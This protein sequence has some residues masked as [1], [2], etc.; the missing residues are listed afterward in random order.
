MPTDAFQL[1]K[2]STIAP[3]DVVLVQ[4]GQWAVESRTGNVVTVS[5]HHRTAKFAVVNNA[6]YRVARG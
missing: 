6:D 1:V 2:G 5:R 4:G 3:R